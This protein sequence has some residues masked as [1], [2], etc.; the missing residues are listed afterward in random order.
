MIFSREALAFLDAALEE[1]PESPAIIFAHCPLRDTVLDRDA[2][3][4]LD[5]DSQ[6]P[7]F[8]VENSEEVRAILARHKNAKLYI[9]G[10]THSGWG[11]EENPLPVVEEVQD[12]SAANSQA[13]VAGS[14]KTRGPRRPRLSLEEKQEVA[15][16]YASTSTPTS[17]ICA[18]LGIGESSVYR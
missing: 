16:L 6:D 1:R 2:E 12:V 17:E 13:P 18:R 4:N 15:R 7:F 10:H 14:S 3:R 11:I 8:F 9:S 5:D